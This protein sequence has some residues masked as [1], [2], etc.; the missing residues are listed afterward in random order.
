MLRREGEPSGFNRI[1]RL[2][3]EEE[4][5]VHNRHARRKAVCYQR[6]TLLRGDDAPLFPKTENGLGE[7]GLFQP[8]GLSR[9]FWAT[10]S[11]VRSIVREA[12]ESARL[13]NFGSHAFRHMLVRGA[14]RNAKTVEEFRAMSQNLGHASMLTTLGSYGDLSKARQRAL[15]RGEV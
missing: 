7:T 3:R 5:T 14:E 9:G 8:M 12:F 6:E 15:I 11:S 13:Q 1:Y 2:Y 4:L 10:A